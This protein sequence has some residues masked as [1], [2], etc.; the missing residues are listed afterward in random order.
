MRGQMRRG[1]R[2]RNADEEEVE[3]HGAESLGLDKPKAIRDLI[4]GE[5]SSV[6]VDLPNLGAQLAF[7]LI[8]LCFPCMGLFGLGI[9]QKNRSN[10]YNS[11]KLETIEMSPIEEW[12]KK[13]WYIYT[14]EYCSAVKNNDFMKFTSKWR[15]QHH[16]E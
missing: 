5:Y 11:Q 14:M 7:M 1:R 8:E 6:V 15:E 10:I 4:A 3:K 9:Y 12:M 13:M 16:L 2:E